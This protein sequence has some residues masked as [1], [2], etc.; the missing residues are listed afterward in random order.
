MDKLTSLNIGEL[1]LS[2][3]KLK[4]L[5]TFKTRWID[6]INQIVSYCENNINLNDDIKDDFGKMIGCIEYIN[7]KY[8]YFFKHEILKTEILFSEIA[9]ILDK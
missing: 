3:S 9:K 7:S 5:E 1:R 6:I 2:L 8:G 4:E